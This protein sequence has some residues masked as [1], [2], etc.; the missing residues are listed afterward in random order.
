[1][2]RDLI[3]RNR[4][5]R[6]DYA[7]EEIYEAGIALRGSEVKSL[8]AR[9]AS[10]D[11]SYAR[12]KDGEVWL[13]GAH[14]APYGPSGGHGHDPERPRRLLLHKREI[15]RLIG[16]AG[17]AGYTLIPL[18]LYFNDRGYAKV[19][20]ALARGQTKVDKRRKIIQE[21]EERRAREALKRFR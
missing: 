17:Q 20:L 4:R 16:K 15:A 8:R 13:F 1:M 5:A 10:L 9:R 7:I 21:E 14:I 19:E 6:R 3:A 18:S 2:A 11:E 12:V